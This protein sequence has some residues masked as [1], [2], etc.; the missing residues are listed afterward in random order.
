MISRRGK[1][2]LHHSP[3]GRRINYRIRRQKNNP[4]KFA[5]HTAFGKEFEILHRLCQLD[6]F[7]LKLIILY[8]IHKCVL[9]K[10]VHINKKNKIL[11]QNINKFAYDQNICVL[12]MAK[13]LQKTPVLYTNMVT[14]FVLVF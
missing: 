5:E 1:N 10:N 8:I 4:S 14:T 9:L 11:T 6:Y 3:M 13:K 7:L 12:C 2:T